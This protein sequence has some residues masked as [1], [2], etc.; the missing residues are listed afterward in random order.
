MKTRIAP[1]DLSIPK[2]GQ[3]IEWVHDLIFDLKLQMVGREPRAPITMER[4]DEWRK[5]HHREVSQCRTGGVKY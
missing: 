2:H 5:T 1:R 3:A 4:L